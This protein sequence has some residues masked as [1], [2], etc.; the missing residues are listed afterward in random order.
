MKNACGHSIMAVWG[1]AVLAVMFTGCATQV[2]FQAQ[3]PPVWNTLGIQRIAV[4]PFTTTANIALQRQA[5]ALLTNESRSRI[6]GTNHF[7]L[8]N[9][10]EVER[11]QRAGSNPENL[12]DA[13]FSGQVITAVSQDSSERQERRDREGNRSYVTIYSREVQVTFNY[14]LTR[15]RDGT[16]IGPISKTLSNSSSS[17]NMAELS[18]AADMIRRLIQS[19]LSGLGRDVA[20]YT[21]TERRSLM[22][23]TSKD[24]ELKQRVKD[25]DALVKAGNYRSALEAF[26]GIYRET[27]SF[28]AAYNA[29]ILIEAQGN[30]QEAVSFMQRVYGETGNPKASAEAARLRRAIDDAGL[31]ETYMANQSQRDKVIA[32]MVDTLPPRLPT[33]AKV[34]L[35]NNTQNEREL[36][37]TVLSGIME[38]FLLKN[39]MVID[40]NSQAL[41]E[42]ERNYQYSGYVSD[43]EMVSIGNE[44]GVNTFLLVAIIGSGASRHLSV[45]ML[46]IERNTVIYQSPQSDEM[47]L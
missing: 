19:S 2:T 22:R 39:I 28:A 20:P 44:A 46:D 16:M 6:Q 32:L 4:M 38:G 34:A 30:L 5:A 33:G 17:Q 35:I 31:V 14:F 7:T 25:A 42:M 43:A 36:A 11:L 27:G 41:I 29:G 21:A 24:K 40:R 15:A 37:E 13:F 3:R 1:V 18:P 8:V 10:S 47:N 12:I 26:Q 45:R 9:A 23:E